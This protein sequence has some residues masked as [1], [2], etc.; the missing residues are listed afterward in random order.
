MND[1]FSEI[2]KPLIIILFTLLGLFLYTKTA[3]PIPFSVISIQTT[4]NSLFTASGTGKA[5]LAPNTAQLSIGITQTSITVS[6]VQ[7][8]LNTK[9]QQVI[10]E[11]KNLGIEEKN[12]RTTNYS[13]SP[14]YDFTARQKITG[15]TATQNLEIKTQ[16]IELANNIIDTATAS[17]ANVV[18]GVNFTFDDETKNKLEDQARKEAVGAAKVKAES[19]ASAAGI[20]LGRIIDVQESTAGLP[21]PMLQA[22]KADSAG[23]GE[24]NITLGENSIEITVTISYET[25]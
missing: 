19:L 2:R 16:K 13:I 10:N 18:G 4:K 21:V 17:G 11:L 20:R 12:I 23:G 15:Y 1:L 24:T 9:S 8:K 22:F 6:D 3:G 7:E 5:T 25:L 14:T